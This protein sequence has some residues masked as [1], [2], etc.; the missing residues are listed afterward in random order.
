MQGG[1]N[2]G[3]QFQKPFMKAWKKE[4]NPIGIIPPSAEYAIISV[5]NKQF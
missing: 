2:V 5:N 4:I 1:K 3:A